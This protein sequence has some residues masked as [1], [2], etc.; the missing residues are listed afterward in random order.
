MHSPVSGVG[1]GF[2]KVACILVY[3]KVAYTNILAILLRQAQQHLLSMGP[4]PLLLRTCFR[5]CD[6]TSIVFFPA[7]TRDPYNFV[8]MLADSATTFPRVTRTTSALLVVSINTSHSQ[9]KCR[10]K[11][12]GLNVP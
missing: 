3:L 5:L 7:L 1:D 10:Q 2:F 6:S 11:P 12:S 8:P 4:L 9:I